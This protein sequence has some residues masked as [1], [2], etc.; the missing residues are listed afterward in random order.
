MAC[1]CGFFAHGPLERALCLLSEAKGNLVATEP[2]ICYIDSLFKSIDSL[3]EDT[4]RPPG[5]P[6]RFNWNAIMPDE[7]NRAKGIG[8]W[9]PPRSSSHFRRFPPPRSSPSVTPGASSA[10]RSLASLRLRTSASDSLVR[11][12][13]RRPTLTLVGQSLVTRSRPSASAWVITLY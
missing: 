13:A 4:T 10:P 2:L 12:G 3:V 11:C 7:P 6:R 5:H 9:T 8:S 1:F